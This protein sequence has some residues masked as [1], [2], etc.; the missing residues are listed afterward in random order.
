MEKTE[1]IVPRLINFLKN[2][3]I[4]DDEK[5]AIRRYLDSGTKS[6]GHFKMRRPRCRVCQARV[7]TITSLTPDDKW[8]FEDNFRHHVLD[9]GRRPKREAFLDDAVAWVEA[10]R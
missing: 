3:S 5:E 7:G 4:S 1:P 9:H 10:N 8:H 2:K 6:Y